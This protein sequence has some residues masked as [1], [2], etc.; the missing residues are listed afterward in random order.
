LTLYSHVVYSGRHGQELTLRDKTPSEIPNTVP[1][2]RSRRAA[3]AV[4][5]AGA[6][7]LHLADVSG[8]TKTRG[9]RGRV[10]IRVKNRNKNRNSNRKKSKK[11]SRDGENN[12]ND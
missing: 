10:S 3:L 6:A 7:G 12:N 1:V 4:L 5:L 2:L 9:G 11:D 8:A